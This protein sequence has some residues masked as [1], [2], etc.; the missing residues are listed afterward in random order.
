VDLSD[1]LPPPRRALF[2][3]VVIATVFLTI[4]AMAGGI[5]LASWHT[6]RTADDQGQTT[7]TPTV[8]PST[9]T[10]PACRTE[11]QA[12]APRFGAAGTL[13][14]ALLLRTPTSAVWICEDQAGRYY[15]HANR[16]GE[17]AKW[18]EGVTAL[19][20]SGVESDGNGGY[21]VVATDGTVF[22]VDADELRIQHKDG[23]TEIQKASS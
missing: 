10:R 6:S 23:S 18:I 12:I 17:H 11:T 14:I 20:L 15:Y 3:P 9:D 19:F 22:D 13:R 4:I 7:T 2:L 1:D 21:H 8:A 16:G 5:T